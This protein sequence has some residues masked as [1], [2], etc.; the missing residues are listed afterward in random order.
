MNTIIPIFLCALANVA[1]ARDPP[2]VIPQQICFY[3]DK[4]Y[5]D[6]DY[7]YTGPYEDTG[8]YVY[9]CK[10]AQIQPKYFIDCDPPPIPSCPK[11]FT[12]NKCC[13]KYLCTEITNH[14]PQTKKC[15]F[16]RN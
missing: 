15:V 4:T 7:V 13:P 8:C 2:D 9:W 6:E 11:E 5:E 12:P 10:N 14:V 1:F 3:D 16:V